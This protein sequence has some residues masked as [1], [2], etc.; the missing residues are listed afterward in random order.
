MS[1]RQIALFGS[2]PLSRL[3]QIR[4][5]KNSLKR[6]SLYIVHLERAAR[7]TVLFVPTFDTK[8]TECLC[9]GWVFFLQKNFDFLASHF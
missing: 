4:T 6:S 2:Q 5:K 3:N 7:P 9:S 8:V 1:L